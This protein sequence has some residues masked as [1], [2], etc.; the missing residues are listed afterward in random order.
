M[1]NLVILNKYESNRYDDSDGIT[2]VLDKQ[3]RQVKRVLSWTTRAHIEKDPAQGLPKATEEDYKIAKRLLLREYLRNSDELYIGDT[4]K[5]VK[6]RK[7]PKGLVGKVKGFSSA[8]YGYNVEVLYTYVETK[9]GQIKIN[10]ENL[11]RIKLSRN[12]DRI[13]SAFEDLRR[14]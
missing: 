10:S 2:V 4:V 8:R 3:A 5:I 9:F 11:K 7:Y 1:S 6:G 13:E 12:K 14:C